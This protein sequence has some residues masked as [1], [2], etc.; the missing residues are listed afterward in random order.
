M[1]YA[2]YKHLPSRQRATL[3]DVMQF[4]FSGQLVEMIYRKPVF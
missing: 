2:L 1:H 3:R 4:E